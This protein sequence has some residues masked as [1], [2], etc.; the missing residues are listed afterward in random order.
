MQRNVS[1]KWS[2]VKSVQGYSNITKKWLLC[3]HEKLEIM[4]CPNQKDFLKK[5]SELTQNVAML[6]SP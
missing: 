4:N 6:T 2:A 3:L 5:W 1:L